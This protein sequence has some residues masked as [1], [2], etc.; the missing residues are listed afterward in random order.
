MLARRWVAVWAVVALAAVPFA[1]GLE[2]RLVASSEAFSSEATRVSMRLRTEFRSP[3]A[4]AAV[5]VMRGAGRGDSDAG[6]AVVRRV[7]A[8]L[9]STGVVTRA[10][11]PANVLDTLLVGRATGSPVAVLGLDA[12]RDAGASI[13]SLRAAGE[14]ARLALKSS[15]P[16]LELL[17]TGEPAL[18]RDLRRAGAGAARSAELRSLPVAVLV[19]WWAFG[20]LAAALL[21]AACGALATLVA[22]GAIGAVALWVPLTLVARNMVSLLALTLGTDYALLLMW[23]RREGG[24]DLRAGPRTILLA[25]AAVAAGLAPLLMVNATEVR[26]AGFAALL[27]V[28]VS[29]A[30]ATTL[31]P[32]AASL[33]SR[34]GSGSGA[35]GWAAARTR[36]RERSYVR[37]SQHARRVA[38][39]PWRWLVAASLP[40]LLLGSQAFRVRPVVQGMDWLP[41]SMESARAI[42][43]LEAEGRDGVAL[44]LRLIADLP[45][46]PVLESRGWD[47][48]G[49]SADRV[50]SI[51]DVAAVR[52]IRTAAAGLPAHVARDVLPADVRN[53]FVSVSGEAAVLE[54]A[55]SASIDADGMATLVRSLRAINAAGVTGVPGARLEV[56][57]V[58]AFNLDYAAAITRGIP[59][60]VAA[61]IGACLLVMLVG[62]RSPVIALKAVLL[63][64]LSVVAA[65]GA[66]VLVFQDGLGPVTPLGGLFPTVLMIAFC[67]VFG[68]SMDYEV[69]L[70]GR[71]AEARRGGLNDLD[72]IAEG[73]G[74]S[75]GVITGAAAVM[76]S[77]F[78]VFALSGLVPMRLTGFLLALA[79][80]LDASLIRLVL[81]PALL[82]IAGR[83]NWWPGNRY[84]G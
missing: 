50:A 74:R 78:G 39:R 76:V 26:S 20:S 2:S 57:G 16:D 14:R 77:V 12:A 23:R 38:S 68:V 24:P 1:R 53:A 71:I 45:A 80:A 30:V 60:A 82:A 11:S 43:L 55:P 15:H 83:W 40:L 81:A 56:G 7:M 72:A 17:F 18:N 67:A 31:T 9:D 3:F 37:W 84:P 49:G 42:R 19:A 34:G 32:V 5:L 44:G 36:D 8:A 33:V 22:L 63:N 59:R 52:S 69:F 29:V 46:A 62:F 75:A 47:A 64:L 48:L 66:A 27:T 25:G 61:S 54:V 28:A 65:L 13:D 73:M 58:P 4:D 6:R 21:A 79:I 70:V 10:A 41:S 35:L 51:P